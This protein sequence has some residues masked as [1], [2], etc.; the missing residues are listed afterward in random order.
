MRNKDRAGE[1][2]MEN[3]R[4]NNYGYTLPSAVIELI[5]EFEEGEDEE[6]M[7][8]LDKIFDQFLPSNVGITSPG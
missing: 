4:D 3:F 6:K 5:E 8:C 2:T 7:E 1:S